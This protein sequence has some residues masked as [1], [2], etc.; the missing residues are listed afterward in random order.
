MDRAGVGLLLIVGGIALM[1]FYYRLNRGERTG[2][3]GSIFGGKH[4]DPSAISAA[5][6][7]AP[8]YRAPGEGPPVLPQSQEAP[9]IQPW[10]PPQSSWIP[11]GG[12]PKW[13]RYTP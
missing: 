6:A 5:S 9:D 8:S 1:V 2:L 7:A 11:R 10:Q 13:G 3:L 12:F 4:F